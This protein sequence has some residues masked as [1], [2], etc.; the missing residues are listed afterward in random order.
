VLFCALATKEVAVESIPQGTI[1]LNSFIVNHEYAMLRSAMNINEIARRAGVSRATVSR[2]LNNGYVSKEKR[3]LIGRIIEETGYIPSQRGKLLRTGK[4]RLVGVIM[5]KIN[6]QSVSRMV[7]GITSVLEQNDYHVV[8]AD[9]E[10]HE[11]REL[12]FLELFS[13]RNHV[14]GIIL[15]ATV[16]TQQHL[17]ALSHM[18]VPTV[19]LAQHLP[20]QSCVYHDDYQALYDITSLVLKKAKRPAFLGV[21]EKDESAGKERH[22]GFIDACEDAGMSLLPGTSITVGFDADSGYFGAERILDAVPDV[23]TIVCATDEIAFGAMMCMHE[24]GRRVPEDVQITGVGDSLLSRIARPSLTTVHL[25]FKTSG[26]RA[27][28]LLL[29]EMR[30]IDETPREIRM[31]FDIYGRTSIR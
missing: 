6:S 27:A 18:A 22:R 29:D 19:V 24:Y 30:G 8:L 5:P 21:Y 3:E 10:N 31:G 2:Y 28:Q 23:D 15:I 7:A 11:N 1:L 25:Y 13:G 9:T 26:V 16:F 12:E 4:T 17:Q 20:G 14:D